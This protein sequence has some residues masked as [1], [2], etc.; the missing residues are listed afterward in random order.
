MFKTTLKGL[1]VLVGVMLIYGCATKGTEV[2]RYV[3]IKDRV[4]QNMDGN[5]GY[6]SGTPQPEDRSEFR[7]TRKIYVLEISQGENTDEPVLIEDDYAID[8]DVF[9]DDDAFMD[10]PDEGAE[11]VINVSR[12]LTA[13]LDVVLNIM[14]SFFNRH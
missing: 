6:L 3:D 4:D 14:I 5:A 11:N 8:N 13:T 1:S 10:D 9:I 2:R 12:E 7:K